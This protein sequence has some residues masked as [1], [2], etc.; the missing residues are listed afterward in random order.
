[1]TKRIISLLLCALLLAAAAPAY[2]AGDP[3]DPLISESY[4]TDVFLPQVTDALQR[5][6]QTRLWSF[7]AGQKSPIHGLKT[8]ALGEGDSLTLTSGQQL[9]L[10]SG[11]VNLKID[12]GTLLNVT[13]G[14]DS[15]GGSA[16][17]GNRYVL[18][19]NSQVTAKATA[20]A[21]VTVSVGVSA[22]GQT[23]SGDLGKCPFTDVA[24][25]A[26]YYGDVVS[27]WK[28]G[29]V[30]GVSADRYEPKGDLTGAAAVKLAACMHQLYHTGSVTLQNAA[31][32]R[33][34]YMSYVDY[35]LKNGIMDAGMKNYDAA[36]TRGEFI[37]LFYN[38]LPEKEYTGINLIMDGA[39]PDVATDAP[40]AKQVYTFYTAGILT[41]YTAGDGYLEHAFGPDTGI[42]RAEVATVMNR[43]FDPA[44][45]KQFTMD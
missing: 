16:Q 5:A 43:M 20:K 29:L 10:L 39:I 1:M 22:A 3:D 41:G 24:E 45:R 8:V 2:A 26:W 9:V 17:T 44:A 40:L 11:G 33:A 28:R 13:A 19:G 42:S 27:A 36:I 14:R 12:K 7:A 6:A 35:A 23:A 4:V 30:N 18:C 37:R 38:A 15:V 32:G 34:W 21:L 31:D 25:T